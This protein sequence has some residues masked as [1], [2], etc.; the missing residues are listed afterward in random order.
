MLKYILLPIF[1]L[2]YYTF[3]LFVLIVIN[4]GW[5]LWDFK[6]WIK[7]KKENATYDRYGNFKLYSSINDGYFWFGDGWTLL[8]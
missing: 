6:S 3:M 7:V 1:K 2:V 5:L 8:E 4:T